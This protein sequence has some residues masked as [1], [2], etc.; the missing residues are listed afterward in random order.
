MRPQEILLAGPALLLLALCVTAPGATAQLLK[1][2]LQPIALT[3]SN[4]TLKE[5]AQVDIYNRVRQNNIFTTS[6][7][8]TI[9]VYL[10]TDATITT[11]DTLWFTI[12]NPPLGWLAEA[13][14]TFKR[15][16]PR[17]VNGPCYLG[18]Y[19]DNKFQVAETNENNN[20][21]SIQVTCVTRKPDW[22]PT[23]F[24]VTGALTA[25]QQ[26]MFTTTIKN[27]GE[28]TGPAFKVG[29]YASADPSISTG[30]DVLGTF[31]VPAIAPT[32]STQVKHTVTL[33]ISLVGGNCWVGVF[34]DSAGAALELSESNN[35]RSK[36]T[37]TLAVPGQSPRFLLTGDA[38][39]HRLGWAVASAGDVNDDGF[40]DIVA[41]APKANKGTLNYVGMVRIYSG[42]NG[43]T[44]RSLYGVAPYEELGTSVA[45]CGD[46]NGDGFDDVV[47]GAP[48][49]ATGLARVFSGKD[50]AVLHTLYGDSQGNDFGHSVAGL[51][52]VD[53]DGYDDF[54]VGSRYGYYARMFSGRTGTAIRTLRGSGYF[55]MS[56]ASVGDVDGDGFGDLVIGAPNVYPGGRAYLY[57]GNTGKSLTS[58]TKSGIY[59]YAY[60]GWSVAGAGDFDRDGVPDVVVG[61]YRDQPGGS[62]YFERGS[63]HVF[64]GKTYKLLASINGRNRYDKM[65][66][67][68]S[69]GGDLNGDGYDDVIVGAYYADI[70]TANSPTGNVV[71]LGGKDRKPL[72]TLL[73][74]GNYDSFGYG[75]CVVG[76]INDD[77]I[78]DLAIGAP[79]DDNKGSS[80]GSVQVYESSGKT[81]GRWRNYGAGCPSSLAKQPRNTMS[82]L[83]NLGEKTRFVLRAAPASTTIALNIA[84]APSAVDFGWYGAPGCTGLAMPLIQVFLQSSTQGTF[85]LPVKVPNDTKLLGNSAYIQWWAVDLQQNA[86]GVI[87]SDGVKL[88]VGK[89]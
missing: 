27:Q 42:K 49:S 50:W 73:G 89:L 1:P 31:S 15:T 53:G 34:V 16:V 3:T 36:E 5:G 39:L 28:I 64:S 29:Y 22:T 37:F 63:A 72:F 70:R 61:A 11:T 44:L 57:S 68:V 60:L 74:S 83:P 88:T 71:V 75:V 32:K 77:G 62:A 4:T 43:S 48:G 51:G 13:Y 24:T 18:L 52:D 6:G 12:N 17:F 81:V 8:C 79:D 45:G 87:V 54:V 56:V 26:V 67:S 58:F 19:V 69:G 10:S 23:A 33:P 86:L 85:S 66:W 59:A 47:A 41:G 55:G 25:G 14:G 7:A 76:D 80:S 40:D 82:A 84:M 35:A 65:G 20:T 78:P 46:V 21:R 30:D 38:S 2:D 9:G